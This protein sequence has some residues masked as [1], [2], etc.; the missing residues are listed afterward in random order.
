VGPAGS[1]LSLELKKFSSRTNR[2]YLKSVKKEQPSLEAW[3]RVLQKCFENG[4]A[5][6]ETRN[7]ATKKGWH[8]VVLKFVC[9][10]SCI[11]YPH[12]KFLP[13]TNV[14]LLVF[15]NHSS[16][17]RRNADEARHWSHIQASLVSCNMMKRCK[18]VRNTTL[19]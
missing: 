6:I 1:H 15:F 7:K 14:I 19:L 10:S 9:A 18:W 17:K 8:Y 13:M 11:I 12:R 2:W 16:Q 4:N 5:D 3:Y